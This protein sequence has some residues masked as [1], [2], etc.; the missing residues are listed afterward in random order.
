MDPRTTISA[1]EAAL[2]SEDHAS[3]GIAM[4]EIERIE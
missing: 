4:S 2:Q 1:A 3:L